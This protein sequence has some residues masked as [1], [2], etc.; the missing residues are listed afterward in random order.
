[1]LAYHLWQQAH[2]PP[3]EDL[4]FW[5][6][7]EEQLFGKRGQQPA[8]NAKLAGTAQAVAKRATA[9]TPAGNGS[10]KSQPWN[11]KKPARAR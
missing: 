6:Q 11:A 4:K 9:S 8:A 10:S 1:M 2:C 3:G 7:A 5:L